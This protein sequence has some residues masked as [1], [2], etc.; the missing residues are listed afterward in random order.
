MLRER[1][2]L[3]RALQADGRLCDSL[4]DVLKEKQLSSSPE[5]I[6]ELAQDAE[7][8]E[9]EEFELARE[10]ACPV[11]ARERR[12]VADL[13]RR[14]ERRN[15]ALRG[16]TVEMRDP[17]RGVIPEELAQRLERQAPAPVEGV[18]L[19]TK[20]ALLLHALGKLGERHRAQVARP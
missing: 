19:F 20:R 4:P 8:L 12:V 6:A 16:H 13:D 15:P 2:P 10:D 11:E 3:G 17:P 18:A 1:D 14:R 9:H 5:R 7:A